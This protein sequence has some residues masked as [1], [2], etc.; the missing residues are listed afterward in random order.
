MN[1]VTVRIHS[2][3]IAVALFAPELT[4]A[5]H[6]VDSAGVLVPAI[7][8]RTWIVARFWW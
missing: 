4:D 5:I 7:L 3:L 1:S 6:V 2:L 8:A